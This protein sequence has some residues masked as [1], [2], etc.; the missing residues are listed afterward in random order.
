MASMWTS[1]LF[2]HNYGFNI[3]G[4]VCTSKCLLK[5]NHSRRGSHFGNKCDTHMSSENYE[6]NGLDADLLNCLV[7]IACSIF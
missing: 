3:L 5:S 2:Y 4:E 6:E 7:T 1:Y